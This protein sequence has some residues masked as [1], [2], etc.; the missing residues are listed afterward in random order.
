MIVR[1]IGSLKIIL[2]LHMH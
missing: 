2:V 1:V